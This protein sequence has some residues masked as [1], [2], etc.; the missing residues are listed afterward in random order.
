MR[1]KELTYDDVALLKLKK[2]QEFQG[3]LLLIT[4]LTS[5][6]SF[7]TLGVKG[8]KDDKIYLIGV[9]GSLAL[10]LVLVIEMKTLVKAR[11]ERDVSGE[12]RAR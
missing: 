1:P 4:V 5:M 2:R 7:S 8:E 9:T 10:A 3:V 12:N 11:K 6:F